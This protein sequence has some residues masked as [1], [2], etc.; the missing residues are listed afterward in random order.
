M[1]EIKDNSKN[2]NG[3]DIIHTF[4]GWKVAFITFA[5][6]YGA[7]RVLKRHT[8][9]DEAFVLVNGKATMF[10]A[11]CD[12]PLVETVMEKEK[13]YVVKQNTWHHLQVSADAMLI[14]VENSDTTKA[15]TESKNLTVEEKE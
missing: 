4:D 9:T 10:T 13:L 11:D 7:L 15:N 8:Q 1:I 12:E 5:P 3:F 6:Q 14:V 2:G